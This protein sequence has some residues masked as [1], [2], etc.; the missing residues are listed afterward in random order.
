MNNGLV[1]E[2]IYDVVQFKPAQIFERFAQNVTHHRMLA[3]SD[4]SKKQLG[5][6]HKTAG[7]GAYGIN[8]HTIIPK[9]NESRFQ[10]K[11]LKK[12]KI[13]SEFGS[14]MNLRHQI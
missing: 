10:A 11:L 14:L 1:I 4:S 8:V 13:L 7:N 6:M 12:G 5:E 3:D 9:N 2:D